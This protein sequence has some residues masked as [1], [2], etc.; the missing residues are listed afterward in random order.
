[1]T[2]PIFN[3][4]HENGTAWKLSAKDNKQ[5][6]LFA[7]NYC[8]KHNILGCVTLTNCSTGETIHADFSYTPA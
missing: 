2:K 5:A 6:A 7:R 1:M 4:T 8:L 3:A